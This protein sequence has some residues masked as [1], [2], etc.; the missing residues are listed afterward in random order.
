MTATLVVIGHGMV[1]HRLVDTLRELDRDR[2]WRVVVLGEEREPAY[3]RVR[4]SAYLGGRSRAELSLVAH[5]FLADPRIEVRSATTAV[6]VDRRARTVR[7]ADGDVL[8]YDA[9]VLATGSRPFVP[10][11]PGR[12]H[13]NCFV[14]RTLED[15]DALRAAVRPGRPAVVVG[16]GLLGL[17]AAQGLQ[18]LGMRPHLVEA[19]PHLMPAQLDTEAAHV[20]R[21]GADRLGLRLHCG[22]TVTAVN[23]GAHGAVRSVTLGDGTVLD[24]DL[25]VFAAG[26]RPRDD[27]PVTPA[28]RLGDRGGYLTDALCRTSDDRVW[29]VGECAAV[30]GRCHG[31]VAPGYRMARSVARQLTGRPDEPLGAMDT[32]TELKLLGVHVAT[33]GSTSGED[34]AVEMTFR[35]SVS[36]Y[37]KVFLCRDTG[38]LL[39]GILAGE[40]GSRADLAARVGRPPAADLERVLFPDPSF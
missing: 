28:L 18:L 15:T 31:L 5:E 20:L 40:T 24:A 12:E 34:G 35:E 9:L 29:A 22:T 38:V 21:H 30:R 1:G 32:S 8:P 7:T 10:P 2:R 37:A 14:Q 36:R 33:F 16:G 39:G 27:L 26:V 25:V 6:H 17:E 13:G 19:A 23:A 3:D 4:L 11:V